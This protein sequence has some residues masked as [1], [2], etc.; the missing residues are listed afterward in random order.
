MR[1]P[2]WIANANGGDLSHHLRMWVPGGY[3]EDVV[4]LTPHLT[5]TAGIRYEFA[6]AVDSKNTGTISALQ[7]Q[8]CEF[9]TGIREPIE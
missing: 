6:T 8:S 1:R 3:A 5:L 7:C 9:P 2:L 4:K